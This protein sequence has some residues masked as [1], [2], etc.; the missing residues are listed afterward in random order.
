MEDVGKFYDHL[1][2]GQL[3]NFMAISYIV[4]LKYISP[5]LVYC[6]NKNL[7]TLVCIGTGAG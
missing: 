6:T 1:V 4:Y 5:V 3:V 2:Y 7:A